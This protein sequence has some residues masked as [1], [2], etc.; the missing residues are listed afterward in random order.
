MIGRFFFN[1]R[2]YLAE[3]NRSRRNVIVAFYGPSA[4]GKSTVRDMFFEQGWQKIKS[5]TTRPARPG[6]EDEYVHIQPDQFSELEAQNR[7]VNVNR[8]YVG[9]SYGIDKK[10]LDKTP[11]G[12]MI[13]DASSINQLKSEIPNLVLIYVTASQESLKQRQ[14]AR[15]EKEYTPG[16]YEERM[17]QLS[18]ELE[19]EPETESKAD[20][21]IRT[22]EKGANEEAVQLARS[23]RGETIS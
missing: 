3:E 17:T 21:I 18:G 23:L 7:L 10:L 5:Y 8:S 22:D 13:T 14:A 19:A 15:R 12:V 2:R 4:S 20:Y 11:F 1:W 16:E 6:E 9:A